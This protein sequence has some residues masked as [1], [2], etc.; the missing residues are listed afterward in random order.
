MDGKRRLRKLA[1]QIDDLCEKM[2]I[3]HKDIA[4]KMGVSHPYISQILARGGTADHIKQIADALKIDPFYFDRYHILTL[5]DRMEYGE[6]WAGHVG[7]LLIEGQR[8]PKPE[9]AKILGQ[10]SSLLE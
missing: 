7:N 8:L 1:D 6:E 3:L 4:D 2:G 10:L 9:Q 5:L